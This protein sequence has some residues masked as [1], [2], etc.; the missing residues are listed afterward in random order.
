[1]FAARGGTRIYMA[2]EKTAAPASDIYSLGKLFEEIA[3]AWPLD[4]Q[5]ARD[6]PPQIDAPPWFV[7]LF[8]S[9]CDH[10]PTKRPIAKQVADQINTHSKVHRHR[11]DAAGNSLFLFV[12]VLNVSI[13]ERSIRSTNDSKG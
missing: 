7:A 8:Q 6:A 3:Q 1:M 9:M 10:N 5:V 13:L 11:H 12:D 2:P 4:S